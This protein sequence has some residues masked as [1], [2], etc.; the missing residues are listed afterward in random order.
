MAKKAKRPAEMKANI[1]LLKNGLGCWFW[2][3]LAN[4]GEILANSEAYASKQKCRQ[5][6]KRLSEA[7]GIPI[8]E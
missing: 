6:A 2:H 8:K 1:V 5:T 3:I 7:T 4:N